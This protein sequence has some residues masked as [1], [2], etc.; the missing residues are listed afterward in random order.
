M[1][2]FLKKR[3]HGKTVKALEKEAGDL[4][5]AANR[6]ETEADLHDALLE[7]RKLKAS[8]SAKSNGS[9][10]CVQLFITLDAID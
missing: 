1:L 4:L 7:W 3:S 9:A 5:K 10:K 8:G 2:A 6:L